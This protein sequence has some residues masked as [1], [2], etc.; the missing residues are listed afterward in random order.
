MNITDA[1]TTEEQE[2]IAAI[3]RSITR[4]EIVRVNVDKC[5]HLAIA[6]WIATFCE[7]VGYAAFENG[8]RRVWG[9]FH[10]QEFNLLLTDN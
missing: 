5:D 1:I 2:I 10:K 7:E 9:E 6:E 3:K 4:D 8:E